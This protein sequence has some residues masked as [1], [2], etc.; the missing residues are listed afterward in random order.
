MSSAAA[1]EAPELEPS[2]LLVSN[3]GWFFAFFSFKLKFLL[4]D[5]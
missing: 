2:L 3:N 4:E 1:G 5:D